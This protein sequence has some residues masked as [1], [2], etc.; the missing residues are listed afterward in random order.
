VREIRFRAWDKNLNQMVQ[1]RDMSFVDGVLNE[2]NTSQYCY[3]KEKFEELAL[4]QF[5]GLKDK[6]GKDIYEGDILDFNWDKGGERGEVYWNSI[7]PCY[8]INIYSREGGEGYEVIN[9][10]MELN[11]IGNVWE[12]PELIK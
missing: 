4:M 7:Q 9:N 6:N 8:L 12:N 3:F 1:V 11:V 2:I 5:T 10:T